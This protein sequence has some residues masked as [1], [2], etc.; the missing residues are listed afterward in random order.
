S[1]ESTEARLAR[2]R[3]V[4]KRYVGK[5]LT[6]DDADSITNIAAGVFTPR[7]IPFL[8]DDTSEP[9]APTELGRVNVLIHH[10]TRW[11]A[12]A[13]IA[14]CA[15]DSPGWRQMIRA[16]MLAPPPTRASCDVDTALARLVVFLTVFKWITADVHDEEAT[17]YLDAF[18]ERPAAVF[19]AGVDR[20]ASARLVELPSFRVEPVRDSELSKLANA[21]LLARPRLRWCSLSQCIEREHRC[22]RPDGG[23]LYVYRSRQARSASCCP[24]HRVRRSEARRRAR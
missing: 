11:K 10:D 12:A 8:S 7:A 6:K 2:F 13:L 14:F 24:T 16:W 19:D 22:T 20:R 18:A 1:S 4:I 17:A 21:M 5:P 15:H 9:R 3:D 23:P